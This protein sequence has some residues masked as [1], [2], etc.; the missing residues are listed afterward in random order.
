[1]SRSNSVFVGKKPVMNYILATLTLFQGGESEV[2]IKARGRSISRTVDI[3]EI[4]RRR[5]MQDLKVKDIKV[6][7]EQVAMEE[8]GVPT[9]VNTI[10][11]SLLK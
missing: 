6:G 2:C 8:G 5:F 11:I 4:A 10:E 9:N 3:V 1:M 7:T